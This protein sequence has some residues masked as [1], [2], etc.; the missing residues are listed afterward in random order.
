MTEDRRKSLIKI[1]QK[2][3]TIMK[4]G[5]IVVQ[6]DRVVEIRG[7]KKSK[8]F[9]TVIDI[10]DLSEEFYTHRPDLAM[11]IGRTVDVMWANGKISYDF[12]ENSLKVVS[13]SR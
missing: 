6:C 4:I 3:V 7:M 10:R 12:S 9:G 2:R 5:D 11:M 1:A 8:S 13:E